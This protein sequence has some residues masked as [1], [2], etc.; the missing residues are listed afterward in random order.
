MN[1]TGRKCPRTLPA[2]P[3]VPRTVEVR[4]PRADDTVGVATGTLVAR[5]EVV[6]VVV[7][8]GVDVADAAGS[9]S[10][11][12]ARTV[13]IAVL[14]RGIRRIGPCIAMLPPRSDQMVASSPR[15]GDASP[16]GATYPQ[17]LAR[18]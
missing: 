6:E 12:S 17:R 1:R 7:D 15:C 18:N 13:R 16:N 10:A 3:N 5:V 8:V 9:A 2:V 14:S 4:V 11:P